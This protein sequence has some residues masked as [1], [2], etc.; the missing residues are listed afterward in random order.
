MT[1]TL[2]GVQGYLA[3]HR[4]P[5]TDRPLSL[6]RGPTND[7]VLADTAASRIHA[8]VRHNKSG[9]VLKDLGSGNGT[10][11]NGKRVTTYRL[12]SGDMI[13]IGE[14]V[15]RFEVTDSATVLVQNPAG[16][17]GT[18]PAGSRPSSG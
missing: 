10:Y 15:F 1:S 4:F 18:A 16:S 12:R 8:E 11:V 3:G 13:G 17:G 14:E 7:V 9:V 6:G 5:I 2:V